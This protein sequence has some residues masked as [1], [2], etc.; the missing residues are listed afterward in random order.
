MGNMSA[1]HFSPKSSSKPYLVMCR[2]V[3]MPFF[4][5]FMPAFF[6]HVA[7]G[8]LTFFLCLVP[9]LCACLSSLIMAFGGVNSEDTAADSIYEPEPSMELTNTPVVAEP[10]MELTPTP[11]VAAEKEEEMPAEEKMAA[12]E[13]VVEDEDGSQEEEAWGRMAKLIRAKTGM[14]ASDREQHLEYTALGPQVRQAMEKRQWGVKVKT[15]ALSMVPIG[16]VL[17]VLLCV[18]SMNVLYFSGSWY[19]GIDEIGH[20]IEDIYSAEHLQQTMDVT[21]LRH[22]TKRYASVM[23]SQVTQFV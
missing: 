16:C 3:W 7:P 17:M 22:M 20:Q 11:V 10:S 8:C 13:E 14:L 12:A 4:F 18:E 19:E 23:M 15:I 21:K 5:T 2:V 1:F 6:T 9:C